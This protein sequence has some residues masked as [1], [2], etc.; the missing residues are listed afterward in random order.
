M[1][2]IFALLFLIALYTSVPARARAFDLCWSSE[3]MTDTG[4]AVT[5]TCLSPP[6][7]GERVPAQ[8]GGSSAVRGWWDWEYWF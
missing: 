6:G 2:R 7:G 4:Y 5:V 1:K 8:Y 3:E